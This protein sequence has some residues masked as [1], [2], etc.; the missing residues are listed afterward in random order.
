MSSFCWFVSELRE[1][2]EP[3]PLIA[4]VSAAAVV[5]LATFITLFFTVAVWQPAQ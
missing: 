2:I 1:F 4:E 3:T 5:A